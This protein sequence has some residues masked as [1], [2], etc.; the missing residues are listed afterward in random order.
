VAFTEPFLFDRNITGGLNVFRTDIRYIGQFTQQSTGFVG[1]MGFPL[2]NGF[3]RMFM[4]YSYERVRVSEISDQ[5]TDPAVLQNNPFLADSLLIGQNGERVIS[6]VTPSIVHNT[7]DNPIFPTSGRRYSASIDLAGLGGNTN[8]YKPLLEGV[9]YWKQ[10]NRLTLGTRA[11]YQYIHAFQGAEEL[12]IFEKLSL[13]G[14]YSVRGF[15]IRTIGLQ[16]RRPRRQQEH[17]VQH[18]GDDLDCR[19]GAADPVLRRGRSAA[20]A[21][22][23]AAA[24]VRARRRIPGDHGETGEELQLQRLQD[25]DGRRNPVLHAGA[26]RA[27]PVDLRVQPAA[28]RRARQLVPAAV[29]L[30]VP[31]CRRVDVLV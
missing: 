1:T 21:R 26:E 8:F 14:E 7:V 5:Y 4:N 10:S 31:L 30:P 16:R 20:G 9:W 2:G 27:V 12:P 23:E 6:K 29:G 17:P 11:Q 25:L 3:T 28:V 24:G 15:D 19:A 22:A 18:R 13:G